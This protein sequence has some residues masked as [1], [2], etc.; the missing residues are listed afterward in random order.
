MQSFAMS[1]YLF[2]YFFAILEL[3]EEHKTTFTQ[4]LQ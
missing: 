4:L 2:M 3:E 1:N